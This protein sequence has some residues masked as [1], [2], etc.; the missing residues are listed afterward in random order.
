MSESIDGTVI[1][2]SFV[3]H[4]ASNVVNIASA[5]LKELGVRGGSIEDIVSQLLGVPSQAILGHDL[6]RD[7]RGRFNIEGILSEGSWRKEAETIHEADDNTALLADFI[8]CSTAS[9]LPALDW[10]EL[11]ALRQAVG[12]YPELSEDAVIL[13][14]QCLVSRLTRSRHTERF[15]NGL[16]QY[17]IP[18]GQSPSVKSDS[19]LKLLETSKSFCIAPLALGGAQAVTQLSQ[20]NY[21]SALL[22][23]GTGSVMTLVLIGTVSVGAMIVQ[24]VAQARQDRG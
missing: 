22:T 1:Q 13:A 12:S 9:V 14:F 15:L 5:P 20:G 23:T 18:L 17:D 6:Y 7:L 3:G 8:S 19:L 4:R 24:R 21:V 10:R 11:F 16:Y 2:R